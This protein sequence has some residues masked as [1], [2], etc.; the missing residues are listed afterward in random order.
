MY[1]I[2]NF[3]VIVLFML[4]MRMFCLG[5]RWQ[6]GVGCLVINIVWVLFSMMIKLCLWQIF[7]IFFCLVFDIIVVVGFWMVGVQYRVVILF[8]W[9][10]FLRVLGSS[11]FLF[12]FKLSI[13]MFNSCVVLISLGQESCFVIRVLLVCSMVISMMSRLCWLLLMYR[14]CW[15]FV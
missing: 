10:V 5:S 12:I 13:L 9:Q 1:L 11:F 7:V 15:C 14:I 3:V 4:L 6:R 2:C 8:V